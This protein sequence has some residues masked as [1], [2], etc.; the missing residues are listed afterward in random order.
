MTLTKVSCLTK[1][2]L[3]IFAA[4]FIITVLANVFWTN[5]VEFYYYVLP[6]KQEINAVY[7]LLPPL[8]FT[9]KTNLNSDKTEFVLNTKGGNLPLTI[10]K[11]IE[12]YRFQPNTFSYTAGK[13][14]QN[15][16]LIL[17]YT[18]T[19]LLTDLRGDVYRWGNFNIKSQL[20]IKLFTKEI[21]LTTDLT[22]PQVREIL[23]NGEIT[24][25]AAIRSTDTLLKELNAGSDPL[26]STA[27]KI[28]TPGKINFNR[29]QTSTSIRDTQFYRVDY[30]RTIERNNGK[31]RILGPEPKKGNISIY[32][33]SGGRNS[34]SIPPYLA[35]PI[36]SVN[37]STIDRNSVGYYPTISARTAWEAL[38]NKNAVLAGI[39]P[40]DKSIL[41][42]VRE[43]EVERVLINDI[44]LAYYENT[45]PQ[46]YLQPIYVFEGNYV[47]AAGDRG[48]I[49]YY[50]PAIQGQYVTSYTNN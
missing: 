1:K 23:R 42:E 16:A 32:T 6:P 26:Y 33:L 9:P 29:I 38:L 3:V 28:A 19:E 25:E 36:V 20:E 34:N 12:V 45:D 24:E 22:T 11:V 48:D 30:F 21:E 35:Y 31:F 43:A 2:G 8:T 47:G 15:L 7:G 46:T 17:G 49:F 39:Y 5:I 44:Y 4:L 50:V 41:E 18:D 14:A 13:D 40:E 27:E 10:P 37:N